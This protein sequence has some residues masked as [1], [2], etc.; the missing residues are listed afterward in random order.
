MMDQAGKTQGMSAMEMCPMAS[1][2]SGMAAKRG[3]G[4]LLLIPGL[5]LVLGGVLIVIEPRALVWL[6]AG[7]SIFIGVVLL[8]F[9]IF[10]RKM[11]ARFTNASR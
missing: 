6:L 8:F 1:M 5:L 7:A 2:C 9:A 11:S 4:S 10:I 3:L